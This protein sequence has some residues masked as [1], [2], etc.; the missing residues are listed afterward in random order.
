[1][2]A[3]SRAHGLDGLRGLAAAAV[4]LLHVWMFSGAHQPWQPDRLDT[5]VG[6]MGLAVMLFFVLSGVL[7]ASPWVRAS[8]PGA[9]TPSLRRYAR[10]RAAR[11]VPGYA[12]C[13]LVAYVLMRAIEH[14]HA[15]TASQLP[16]F[17]LFAQNQFEATTGQ[18]NPP[19]WSLSIEAT[20]YLAMPLIGLALIGA[21]RRSGTRGAL[22]ICA[23]LAAAGLAWNTMVFGRGEPA[24]LAASLPTFLPIFA[25]GIAAAVALQRHQTTRLARVVLLLG[26]SALVIANGWWHAD[27]TGWLGHVVRDLPAGVGFAMV[28]VAVAQGPAHLLGSAPMRRLGD[29]SFGVYLWHM[30]VIYVLRHQDR[31]PDSPWQAFAVVLAIAVAVGAASWY[32]LE[33]PI[34]NWAARPQATKP[35]PV[36]T[37]DTDNDDTA[38]PARTAPSATNAAKV[39]TAHG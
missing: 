5:I 6:S 25:C 24:T 31:W 19:L 26:G 2:N 36:P 4:V 1:M 34:M 10:R 8:T 17:L 29:Y 14:P 11:I 27:G 30:P 18:L 12:A 22:V 3:T 16:A 38:S 28:V 33:R 21:L 35:D 15:I 39:A 37:I 7:I 13:V 23:L 20:F 32:L 9:A